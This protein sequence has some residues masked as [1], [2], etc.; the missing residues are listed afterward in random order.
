MRSE[1]MNPIP[2]R[3]RLGLT[4]SVLFTGSPQGGGASHQCV[5][6]AT[7]GRK[8][9]QVMNQQIQKQQ[10]MVGTWNVRTL[11][12][13]GNIKELCH[14]M[15]RYIWN[16]LGLAE[17]RWPG[18]GEMKMDVGHKVWYIGEEKRREKGVA[19]MV[20]KDTVSSVIQCR[21]KSSRLISIR[22]AA[23]P[24]NITAIQVYAPTG[25]YLGEDVDNFYEDLED[26]IAQI[27]KSD[28]VVVLGEWSAKVGTDA[29]V[30]WN[31]KTG[32]FGFGNT[33]DRGLWRL[34]FAR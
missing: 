30:D 28:I 34:E 6:N 1:K 26:T 18:A 29:Y 8:D 20:N 24:K 33:N 4:T 12:A 11:S 19:F 14:E 21:P 9:Q 23:V 31:G 2:E 32:K 22:I 13:T 7:G 25:S 27:P 5:K 17:V 10:F 16:I 15:K 3:T